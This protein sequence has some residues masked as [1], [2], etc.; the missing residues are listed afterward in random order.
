MRNRKNIL[1]L[2]LIFAPFIFSI[3]Q[4]DPENLNRESV[5]YQYSSDSVKYPEYLNLENTGLKTEV[6]VGCCFDTQFNIYLNDSLILS[7][8]FDTNSST[9]HAGS[10]GVT[11]LLNS[12]NI[13]RVELPKEQVFCEIIL[14]R[15][16]RYMDLNRIG[17]DRGRSMI[18]FRNH[19]IALE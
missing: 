13:L 2:V 15:R 14:D 12:Q 9:S 5:L 17:K 19:L 11:L 4:E 16:Y 10:F 6:R 8:H 18:I 3:A 7:K 1:S